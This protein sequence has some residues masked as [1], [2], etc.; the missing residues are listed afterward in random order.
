MPQAGIELLS[1]KVA[2]KLLVK[3]V[4]EAP[5]KFTDEEIGII[6]SYHPT[7]IDFDTRGMPQEAFWYIL[8]DSELGHYCNVRFGKRYMPV[9]KKYSWYVFLDGFGPKGKYEYE[10]TTPAA[11]LPLNI[12]AGI[13][14]LLKHLES[15]QVNEQKQP[16]TILPSEM[17]KNKY[18]HD[19]D[20]LLK[21]ITRAWNF[22]HE[23]DQEFKF[24]EIRDKLA[25]LDKKYPSKSNEIAKMKRRMDRV[26]ATRIDFEDAYYQI[27]NEIT[28]FLK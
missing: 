8:H 15:Q 1:R 9:E 18:K 22:L 7:D 20:Y 25:E 4:I 3:D 2:D 10:E 24:D 27:K 26:K 6:K 28:R 14:L 21:V 13:T 23:A 5:E 17:E 12:E 19:V 16:E 11:D